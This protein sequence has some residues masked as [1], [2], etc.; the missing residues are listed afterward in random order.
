MPDTYELAAEFERMATD[1]SVTFI[2]LSAEHVDDHIE[3]ALQRLVLFLNFDR[4]TLFQCAGNCTLKATHCWG[5]QE[6]PKLIDYF[7]GEE[8][9]YIFN[10]LEKSK[11]ICIVPVHS[12]PNNSKKDR[13]MMQRYGPQ[14][15]ICLPLYAEGHNLGMLTVGSFTPDQIIPQEKL[16]RLPL[17]GT[18]LASALLKKSMDLSLKQALKEVTRLK[19]L[20]EV[21]NCILHD[22]LNRRCLPLHDMVGTSKAFKHLLRQIERVASTDTTVLILGE[23]G[24]GKELVARSIHSM[25]KRGKRAMI[26]LNCGVFSPE[27]MESELFGHERGA[28]TGA[29]SK[30][31]GRFEIAD[32]SSLF[33]DE[34]GELMLPAQIKLLRF[35][36]EKQFER[37]GSSRPIHVDVRILAATNRDLIMEMQKG[38][39]REDLYYR[40]NVFPIQVPPLRER[41]EDIPLMVEAFVSEFM[42]SMSKEIKQVNGHDMEV[43][44]EYPWPGNVRELRNVVERAMILAAGS[45]LRIPLPYRRGGVADVKSLKDAERQHIL[46]ALEKTGWRVS[47]EKGA[48]KLL[49]I[50]P[51]TLESRMR[52]LGL[53]RAMSKATSLAD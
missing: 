32:G 6:Y 40:L 7:F 18:I 20:M 38:H 31:L 25:S 46:A 51:K 5:K 33:F 17:L 19:N 27:L 50:N 24:T 49:Q 8:Y 47:G 29:V 48:A 3:Y 26:S 12:L 22:D 4:A 41:K 16:N 9:P 35:L 52:R 42:L 15:L 39:F 14:L 34:I 11:S 45:T 10:M 53:S 21:E 1:L 13:E 30:K 23:T 44:Q 43:L 2:N 36:Q 28:F 37:L